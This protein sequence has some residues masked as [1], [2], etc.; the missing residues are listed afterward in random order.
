MQAYGV[1]ARHV[2]DTKMNQVQLLHLEINLRKIYI[3][4]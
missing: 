3:D 2:L 1:S 4:K